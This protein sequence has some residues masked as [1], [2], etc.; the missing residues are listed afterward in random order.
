MSDAVVALNSNEDDRFSSLASLQAAHSKLLKLHRER[1]NEPEI[2]AEIGQLML[3]GQTTGIFL[4]SEDDRWAAQSL[5]D[6][7][8]SL[9]YRAGQE[10]PDAILLDFDP[11]LAPDLSDDLCPYMG[12]EAFHAENQDRF[13]GRQRLIEKLL[14]HLETNRLLIVVG[15]SGSGKSSVVL[16]GLLPQL[17]AGVLPGSQNWFYYTPLVPGSDPLLALTR[18][19]QPANV[20]A[21]E[22]IPQQVSALKQNPN[23]LMQLSEQLDNQPVVLVIDQ[24]EEVFTL[25]RDEEVREAFIHNLLDFCQIPDV[26]NTLI[27]TMRTDF[28]SQFAR[29]PDLFSLFEQS[30]VR[31][32]ALD[33]NE[34][35]ETIEKPAELVGLKFEDGLVDALL[36]DVL[37]EPTALPLLQFTL[38]KLWDNREHNRVTWEAYR[39]LGGGRL[40]LEKSA[41]KFY[42]SLIPEEQLTVK[43][44]LLRMVRPSEGLEITSN[45]ISCKNLYRSGEAQDR[46]DRVLGKLIQEHL[47]RLTEG[48]NP[49]DTQVEIAHEALIRNWPLLIDWLERERV[50]LRQRYRLTDMAEHWLSHEKDKDLLLRGRQLKEAREYDDLSELEEEFI[51]CSQ[52]EQREQL[53]QQRRLK[54]KLRDVS[55]T[56]LITTNKLADADEIIFNVVS[57]SHLPDNLDAISER[58]KNNALTVGDLENLA[59]IVDAII[60]QNV[61]QSAKYNAKLDQGSVQ[62]GDRYGLSIEE[63]RLIVRKLQ[64]RQTLNSPTE[65]NQPEQVLDNELLAIPLIES[66]IVEQINARIA[67]IDELQKVGQL[68]NILQVEF[69]TVKQRIHVFEDI[70]REL[71]AIA[72][73]VNHILQRSLQFLTVKL[74]E[75]D[76]TQEDSLL[77]DSSYAL[78]QIELLGQFQADLIHGKF[79]ARWLKSQQFLA[80]ELG[81][82]ALDTHP[83][84]KATISPRRLE[85]FYLSLEQFLE[86]LGHC[87]T[88]GR[89]NS[90]DNPVT[91]VVLDNEVYTAAFEQLKVLIPDH[92]S[93]NGVEQLQEYIDYLVKSLPSYKHISID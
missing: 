1:G 18:R 31:V 78:K 22:W 32:T 90:L 36:R 30:H 62:I 40:A 8:S 74:Q 89:S 59:Q 72:N 49:D 23:C 67:F 87:L 81:Q 33:A 57:H 50:I 63:I 52:Q 60:L 55:E 68:S 13:F 6:Y 56:A 79:V 64:T 65:S 66:H 58:L 27:L 5:L 41:D 71:V 46:I 75:L 42:N 12:L 17:Q 26:R 82:F 91:P 24:F 76:H 85:A 80:Q 92:L 28:E 4:D 53:E 51:R 77:Q 84:I 70:N 43:R 16:G 54:E 3:K 20:I 48:D 83:E 73:A 69:N 39:R 34:L 29:I 45:R 10:Q 61:V 35:R 9:L 7:W 19:L 21:T 2:L 44:I 47:L 37:G 88:W 86:R 11:S 14:K 15:S 93:D 38:L 25:C